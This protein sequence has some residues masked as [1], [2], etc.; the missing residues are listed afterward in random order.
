V[1]VWKLGARVLATKP[2]AL[3]T[4]PLN[5]DLRERQHGVPRRGKAIDSGRQSGKISIL[6]LRVARGF[7]IV[8]VGD[9]A[10]VR[11]ASVRIDVS[12]DH[13][14]SSFTELRVVA[15]EELLQFTVR[16]VPASAAR[17]GVASL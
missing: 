1:L 12:R 4:Y 9:D 6:L 5:T 14:E 17:V 11:D 16:C 7:A 3:S 13:P 15:K 2:P 8:R 10:I